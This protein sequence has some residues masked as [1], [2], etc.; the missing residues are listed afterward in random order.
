MRV[1]FLFAVWPYLAAALLVSG[2]I[3]RYLLSR[4]HHVAAKRQPLDGRVWLV[5]IVLL[6]LHHLTLLALPRTIL[7]W[8]RVPMRLYALEAVAF[9]V[10]VL[11]IIGWVGVIR[12][13]L[14]A[15][16]MTFTDISDVA[17]LALLFV[18]ILS[19]L[20]MAATYRWGSAWGA[21]T[22]T[23]YAMSLFR[24]QPREGI[25]ISM[26]FLIQLHVFAGITTLALLPFTSLTRTVIFALRRGLAVAMRP[27]SHA[28][29]SLTTS[30][31]AWLEKH[32]PTVWIWPEEED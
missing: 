7:A 11:A 18:A 3:L 31:A 12:R 22:L 21:S 19:G 15:S 29:T 24:G 14:I 9:A 20:A 1:H 26:P 6:F 25:F 4:D 10:G 2:C 32:D 5:S 30:I 13:H 16:S 17:F 27:V 28:V 8:N 23:P